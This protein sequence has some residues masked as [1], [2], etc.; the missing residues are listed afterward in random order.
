MVPV[1]VSVTLPS[2]LRLRLALIVTNS[3]GCVRKITL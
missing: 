2:E 1:Q 3:T